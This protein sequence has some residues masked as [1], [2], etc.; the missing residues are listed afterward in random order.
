MKLDA[1][2]LV[3]VRAKLQSDQAYDESR[4]FRNTSLLESR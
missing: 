2:S 1:L 3:V 4:Y